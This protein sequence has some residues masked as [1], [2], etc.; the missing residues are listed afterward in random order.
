MQIHRS[1]QQTPYYFN[2]LGGAQD[3]PQ[4]TPGYSLLTTCGEVMLPAI[5]SD[6][7]AAAAS[8]LCLW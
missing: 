2:R 8:F 1:Y 7:P 6:P 4:L 5:R 3:A